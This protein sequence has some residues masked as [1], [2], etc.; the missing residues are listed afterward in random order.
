[1]T[2]QL[3]TTRPVALSV[4]PALGLLELDSVAA[5]IEAGDTLFGEHL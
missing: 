1:M 2:D 3:P 4:E 5:G